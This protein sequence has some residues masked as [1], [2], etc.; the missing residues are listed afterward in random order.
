MSPTRHDD[1]RCAY[2]LQRVCAVCNAVGLP[3]AREGREKGEEKTKENVAGVG[4]RRKGE[5]GGNS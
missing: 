3:P 5:G 4:A 2:T 1:K